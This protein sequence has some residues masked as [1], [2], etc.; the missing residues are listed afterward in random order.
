MGLEMSD[1]EIRFLF[2]ASKNENCSLP[3]STSECI[4]KNGPVVFPASDF[5]P[6]LSKSEGGKKQSLSDS[7]LAQTASVKGEV[8]ADERLSA[9]LCFQ[10][11]AVTISMPLEAKRLIERMSGF[12]L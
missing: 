1:Q 5:L 12:P 11:D 4:V 10:A 2:E 6:N 3:K 9:G 8:E 7:A